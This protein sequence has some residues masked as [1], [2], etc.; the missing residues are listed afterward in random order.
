MTPNPETPDAVVQ[1][2]LRAH[3]GGPAADDEALQARV[4]SLE[5]AYAIQEQLFAALGDPPGV[6]RYWKSGG[7]SRSDAMRHA[8]LPLAGV[9][10][11]GDALAGLHL[12]H[13]WIE[14]EVALRIGRAVTP[15][16]AQGLVPEDA[17]ALVDAMCM[18]IEVVDTRWASA[19]QAP[20]LLKVADLLVHGA[21][22]LGEFVPFSPRRWDAQECRV[23][24]GTADR[25]S[26]RGSLG[27]GDPA[28]VLPQWLRH[29]TRHGATV[30]AGTV[31][32]TGSWCGLLDA[33]AGDHVV[34]EFPGIGAASV[35]L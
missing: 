33:K 35:Q 22:V 5:Q 27:V 13:R 29:A 10:P 4:T 28:W 26:F 11:S 32:S 9:R 15:D 25:Q 14:A 30:P 19:R 23:R 7:P 18:A 6:P 3:A 34:A 24:I 17:P 20:L 16:A 31:V 12:R 1:S 2:L 21:L 8:P